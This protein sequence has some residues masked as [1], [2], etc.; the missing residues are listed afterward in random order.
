MKTPIATLSPAV[1][2]WLCPDGKP[3]QLVVTNATGLPVDWLRDGR[4]LPNAQ[5]ATLTI[6]ETGHY[7]ARLTQQG[8]QTLSD[9]VV[10]RRSTVD[11]ITLKPDETDLLLLKKATVTL[12]APAE[13]D[14]TYQW[15]RNGHLLTTAT[16]AQ[17]SVSELGVYNVRVTQQNCIGWSAERTVYLPVITS[18]STPSD[19]A[20]RLYPNPAEQSITV[21]YAYP[22]A[23]SVVVRILDSQGR[24]QQAPVALKPVN[25]L[26]Q[27][28]LPVNHLPAGIYYLQF[29][30]GDR[31][32]VLRFVKK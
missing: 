18:L 20:F 31:S 13:P 4:V 27:S 10:V 1:D 15:Y 3:L 8:C 24:I 29:S 6:G 2:Q 11:K 26:I 14:Y 30:D 22:I 21:Q 25:R 7:Q 32:R 5:S 12:S 9:T 16:G 17:L 23:A 28:T 19:T